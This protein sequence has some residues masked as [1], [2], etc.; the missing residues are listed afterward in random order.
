MEESAGLCKGHGS[1]R[2]GAPWGCAGEGSALWEDAETSIS[3]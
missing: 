1:L 2:Q 3:R